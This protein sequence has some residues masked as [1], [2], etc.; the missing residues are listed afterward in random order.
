MKIIKFTTICMASLFYITSFAEIKILEP[1]AKK[2][3]LISNT[4]RTISG[5]APANTAL[6]INCGKIEVK[7]KS[8]SKGK[9]QAEFPFKTSASNLDF[10]VASTQ[11]KATIK[12]NVID[13]DNCA[14][15]NYAKDK[16]YIISAQSTNSKRPFISNKPTALNLTDGKIKKYYNQNKTLNDEVCWKFKNAGSVTINI[17]LEKNIEINEVKIHAMFVKGYYTL[18]A[19]QKITIQTSVNGKQWKEFK[20]WTNP[21]AKL[22][23]G[24]QGCHFTWQSAVGTAK[25]RFVKIS[26]IND[27]Y[28]QYNQAISVDEIQV[29]GYTTK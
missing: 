1:A 16:K 25:T 6:T 13:K 27:E 8:N 17:D 5:T 18:S 24:K 28:N 29:L 4:K 10:T 19:P 15:I 12:V 26:L 22:A 23:D 2:I 11:E 9:W 3:S 21:P 7:T 14:K 20:E